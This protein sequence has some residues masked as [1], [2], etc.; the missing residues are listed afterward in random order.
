[1]VRSVLRL[2]A[3]FIG[4]L[5]LR[6]I[7]TVAL[8]AFSHMTGLTDHPRPPVPP[9]EQQGGELKQDPVCG[10]F[11]AV[12]S[13]IKKTVNGEVIHF[14]STACRDKYQRVA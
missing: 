11:V 8:R 7:V 9:R 12:S 13:S 1:M 6:Q 10:T 3:I 14:C 5:F 4:A 2:F